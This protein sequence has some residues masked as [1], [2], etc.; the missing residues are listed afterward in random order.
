MTALIRKFILTPDASASKRVRALLANEALGFGIK[1][2]TSNE[3]IEEL[4]LAYLI[5]NSNR[6]WAD[7]IR[8]GMEN[9]RRAFWAKSFGVDPSGTSAAVADSLDQILR[10]GGEDGRWQSN[11]L[12]DRTNNRL[13]DLEELWQA[14]ARSFPADLNI[15][16]E[17][18]ARLREG[19]YSI[20]IHRAEDWPR[21]DK[22]LGRLIDLLNAESGELDT[23]LQRILRIAST[24]PETSETSPAPHLLSKHCFGTLSDPLAKSEA[25]GF[26]AARDPMEEV[27]CSVGAI[28]KL[29]GLGAAPES[30]GILLPNDR[31]YQRSFADAV[32][33]SGLNTAGLPEVYSLRDLGGEVVR[34]LLLFARGPI[35]KMALAALLASPIAPWRQGIGSRL[36]SYVMSGRFNLRTLHDMT[37]DEEKNLATV[38]RLRENKISIP[39][40]IEVFARGIEGTSHSSRLRSLAKLIS[41]HTHGS[42]DVDYDM[43][44][45][46][47]GHADEALE[48]PTVFPQNG[49]RIFSESQEP[50]DEV[51]HL[52]VLGFNSGHYPSIPGTSP[53]FHELEK[54][55]IN[56]ELGWDLPT[57][58]TI[59]RIRRSQF[60][61]QIGSASETLTF[62]ASARH[63]E[64]SSIQLSE[65]ATFIA[66]LLGSE[67]DD[68]FAPVQEDSE[69]IPMADEA[70]PVSL[71]Q[72]V[73]KDI[74]LARDLLV[75]RT[76]D[77]GNPLPES[78]S[79]LETLL[80]SPL[81]WLL[82]RVDA[83]PDPWSADKLDALLQGNIAH[84]VF[85]NLFKVD[86]HIIDREEVETAVDNALGEVIRQQAPLLSTAQWKVERNTLRGTLVQAVRNW[87]DVLEVLSAKVVGVE[88]SLKGEF[89]G[90][91][92]RGFSDQ[93][94]QLPGGALAVVDF[95]KSSSGKRRE[96]MELGYDCQV[97]LYEKM[98][99]DNPSE[100]G[101]EASSETPGII[102][103][104]LNDQRV[105]TDNRT[106]LPNSVPGLIV[107]SNEVSRNALD[108]IT[109]QIKKLKRGL[110]E[111]N[112]EGDAS[113]FAKEKALPDF[114]L[115]A[116]PLVMMFAH[117]DTTGGGR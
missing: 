90:I 34:S 6:D 77:E 91:P 114:A 38:R 58:E 96:R 69:S 19:I 99:N 88:A 31:Y 102:Y 66:G 97:S 39:D 75:L 25:L 98:I 59:L 35:P 8:D 113:K 42:G 29:V 64:G 14:V 47:V 28:Q 48:K 56:K 84:G 21:L 72:S 40:V 103:Y 4:R 2:V 12:S 74:D 7:L 93:V 79:S 92:I 20:S 17:T 109:G 112:H 9:M 100:L 16:K 44:L 57:A 15:V 61:R 117:P 108:E 101:V 24:I 76:D 10:Y 30:I 107:V 36:A 18:E 68:L 71:K 41:E 11:G 50:W 52:Y 104:T 86:D 83:L 3:L 81:T 49:I 82:G 46:L 37:D 85:E 111:M 115:E 73:S 106:G 45:D 13:K 22:Q 70:A 5:P 78:P 116:S 63:A 43:L 51:K 89:S 54:Q 1:V 33:L 65:T 27:E 23:N 60:Q 94:I 87:R 53:I 95:K 110:V 105:V 55:R 26:F 80:V 67:L 32:A 62:F